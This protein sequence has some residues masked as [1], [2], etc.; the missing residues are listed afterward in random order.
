LRKIL[1]LDK[2]GEEGD[3]AKQKVSLYFK[4]RKPEE[5]AKVVQFVILKFPHERAA[6][7]YYHKQ[8]ADKENKILMPRQLAKLVSIG[9]KGQK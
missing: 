4:D 2:N 5:E 1:K 7:V 9:S 3:Q 8:M 6:I